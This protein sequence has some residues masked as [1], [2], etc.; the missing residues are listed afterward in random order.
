M[1]GTFATTQP[2]TLP[3]PHL[4]HVEQDIM[5]MGIYASD[6]SMAFRPG[7]AN[8]APLPQTNAGYYTLPY[9][10][11]AFNIQGGIDPSALLNRTQ[12][13][14]STTTL[15]D[16]NHGTFSP[17]LMDPT[18]LGG[19]T[20][21]SL[22]WPSGNDQLALFRDDSSSNLNSGSYIKSE[23]SSPARSSHIHPDT[24]S[25]SESISPFDSA[26]EC[27]PPIFSTDV[28]TLMKAIQQ[29]SKPA[30]HRQ[31][32]KQKATP[33][34]PSAPTA[35]PKK[36]YTCSLPDCGKAFQQKTHLEI[37][38]RAHTGAKPYLC[39]EPHCNQRF[40]QLGN[41]RTHERRHTGERPYACDLC[42][43]RFAQHGNVRAHKSTHSASKP[44]ECRLDGCGKR[45]TQL[46]NLKAHQNRF[47]GE[48]IRG[49]RRRFEGISEGDVVE[50]WEKE[51][52]EY[53]AGLY[54]NCNKGI[55]GRGKDRRIAGSGGGDG[56]AGRDDATAASGGLRPRQGSVESSGASGGEVA[57]ALVAG[58]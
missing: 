17:F 22:V 8:A 32:S 26:D 15:L 37:H 49:L 35:K 6:F 18:Y 36:R 45:F 50:G 58:I 30:E 14:N 53:F 55:K 13:S 3:E 43:K 48:T 52:W 54:K 16:N 46:G 12:A 9:A 10:Q 31:R 40:S 5:Q 42:G 27:K 7:E 20:F 39:K 21:G 34:A 1:S 38:T 19:S 56:G 25:C 23:A 44:F 41:L 57:A 51:A 2:E 24:S 29:Q 33:A 4:N 28:D 11:Q 47:H